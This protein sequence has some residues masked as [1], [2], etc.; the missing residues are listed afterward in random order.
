MQI[1]YLIDL[2]KKINESREL[3]VKLNS[4]IMPLTPLA[5][6]FDR[7][8]YYFSFLEHA[9][10]IIFSRAP[11]IEYEARVFLITVSNSVGLAWTSC[12]EHSK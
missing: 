8:D 12:L 10:L 7:I 9:D 6:P 3:W 2:Q 4:E 5:H 1:L 11:L